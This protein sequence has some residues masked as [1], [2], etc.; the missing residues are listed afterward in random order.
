M[1]CG[2]CEGISGEN[3]TLSS[4]GVRKNTTIRHIAWSA[5][6]LSIDATRFVQL[7]G[8]TLDLNDEEVALF[9][10]SPRGRLKCHRSLVRR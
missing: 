10:T 8:S 1:G 5:M 2:C 9:G 4:L 6:R 7:L 3:R